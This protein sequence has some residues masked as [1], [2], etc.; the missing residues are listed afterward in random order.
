M[1]IH[2]GCGSWA[3]DEYVAVLHADGVPSKQRLESYAKTFDYAEV[4]SSYYATPRANI[5]AG[6]V[7]QTPPGFVFDIK[8]HRA[9]AQSPVK[10]GAGDLPEKLLAGVAPVIEAGRFGTF[11]IVLPEFFSPKRRKLAELDELVQKLAPHPLAVELRH[12]GWIEEPQREAT[13]EYFRSRGMVWIG[14]DM[15]RLEGTEIMP[16]V[17]EVTN[18]KLA[19]LR[20]HG[21]NPNW[22]EA[23]SA[24]ARHTYEYTTKDLEEIAERVR[25]LST[26][27]ETVHVVAN[28]HASDFAPKAALALKRL[29]AS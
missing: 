7:K 29:L 24:E 23:K 27:A 28:N 21:R 8:L 19:Y 25:A 6:R 13:F 1:K 4:N 12:H 18:P 20:L 10:A 22:F 15:P 26:K 5:T 14:V 3:D 11:F 17:D 9:F 2:I 16:A